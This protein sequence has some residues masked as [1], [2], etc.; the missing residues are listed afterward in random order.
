MNFVYVLKCNNGKYYTGI[1]YSLKK[2]LSEHCSGKGSLFTKAHL[3][4]KLMYFE[5]FLSRKE[6]AL[7]EKVIKD[8]SRKKKLELFSKFTSSESEMRW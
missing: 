4:V 8:M 1:T 7:R 3:P 2:R 6:A 5:S